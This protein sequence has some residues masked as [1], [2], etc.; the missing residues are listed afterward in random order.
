ME[1]RQQTV[2]RSGSFAEESGKEHSLV[3]SL[4][5]TFIGVK[6]YRGA[7]NLEED[8]MSG[9]IRRFFKSDTIRQ[10]YPVDSNHQ[11]YPA[12]LVDY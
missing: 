2:L 6:L 5:R 7:K 12:I 10:F 3:E 11:I 8:S 1:M 4:N 9:T